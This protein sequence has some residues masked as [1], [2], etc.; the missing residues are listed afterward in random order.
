MHIDPAAH[1]ASHNYKLLT[2]I[3][4]PRPIAWVTSCDADGLVNLAPFSFF[5]A[6]GADP[7]LLMISVAHNADGSLKHTGRNIV[8][9][10]EFVVNL[11]T[12]ELMDAMNISAAE[13]PD[14][15]SELVAAGLAPAASAKVAVPRVAAAKAALEC[16]LHSTLPFGNF[17]VIVGEVV[18]F[19][20]DDA[21]MGEKD[22]IHDFFPVGR[23]GSPSWYCRT[24]SRFEAPRVSYADLKPRPD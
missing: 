8:E 23:M 16:R 24:D 12:E 4:V 20:V 5:N 2:N 7:V 1:S 6:I 18:M 11:V 15:E 14:H 22:R 9:R 10:G 13:F 17:T 3:V 21:L 19:H